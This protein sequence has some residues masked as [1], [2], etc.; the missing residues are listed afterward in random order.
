MSCVAGHHR[1]AV[2]LMSCGGRD[3]GLAVLEERPD[4]L[5]LYSIAVTP[6]EQGRGHGGALLDFADQRAAALAV[7]EIR[8]YT[9]A[10]MVDNIAFYRRHGYS[11]T[12]TRPHPSR[13]GEMLVD[14][15]RFVPP[16]VPDR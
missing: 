7:A 13:A 2:W 3:V 10:R 4:H 11:E 5:L 14:M 12:G 1:A 16:L 8:L 9:N 6:T 15:V